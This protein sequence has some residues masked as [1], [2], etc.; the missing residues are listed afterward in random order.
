[1][2]DTI[3]FVRCPV[4]ELVLA[5]TDG[6]EEAW[7]AIVERYER[8]VRA[9]VRRYH[10]SG[11]DVDDVVQ[12]VWLQLFTNISK[13]REPKALPAWIISTTAHA[14]VRTAQVSGRAVPVDPLDMAALH[15][16]AMWAL[17]EADNQTPID[18]DLL[19]EEDRHCVRRAL[20][21]LTSTQRD[22]V[23]QTVADPP[24]RYADISR[25]MGI[26]IG[27]IGPTRGRCL[28]KLRTTV[29]RME[30]FDDVAA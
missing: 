23:L 20:D 8:L 5:A 12:T 30:Q 4:S 10:I 17:G 18:R 29:L 7:S 16:R 2:P 22:L 27:S 13:L 26:P 28:Q 19:R 25:D 24:R 21:E 3:D 9:I 1:M 6:S 11:A 15:D 14:S